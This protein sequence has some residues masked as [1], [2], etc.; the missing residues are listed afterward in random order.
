[1]AEDYSETDYGNGTYAYSFIVTFPGSQ[2]QVR[3]QAFDRRG[4]FVRA[5]DALTS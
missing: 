3:M 5:E 1:M 4:V 2:V